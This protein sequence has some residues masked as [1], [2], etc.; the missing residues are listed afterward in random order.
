MAVFF[1]PVISFFFMPVLILAHFT[2]V[3]CVNY[4]A[5][6]AAQWNP[7]VLLKVP[8]SGKTTLPTWI[9]TLLLKALRVHPLSLYRGAGLW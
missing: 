7:P 8:P 1:V 2:D 5:H 6:V 9:L 4:T 3:V